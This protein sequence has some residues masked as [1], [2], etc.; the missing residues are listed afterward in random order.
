MKQRG[1]NYLVPGYN[2]SWVAG[3]QDVSPSKI[4]CVDVNLLA[5]GNYPETRN[6]DRT[7]ICYRH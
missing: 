6:Q 1:V 3:Y 4:F 5:F 2:M 7:F